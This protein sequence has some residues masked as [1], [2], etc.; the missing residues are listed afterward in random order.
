MVNHF[1]FTVVLTILLSITSFSQQF[2]SFKDPRDGR[3]YKT[4]KIGNQTWM[5]ENL[6]VDKFQNGDPIPEAKTEEE[7]VNAGKNKMPAWCYFNNDPTRRLKYGKLYN[8]YAVIDPRGLTPYSWHI[9]SVEDYKT[10]INFL[11]GNNMAGIKMKKNNGW[12]KVAA[13]K[14][15]SSKVIWISG[16][17]TNSSGW[18]ALPNGARDFIGNFYKEGGV[19]AQFGAWWL[20]SS[21]L[22]QYS[23]SFRIFNYDER[24]GEPEMSQKSEG[25]SV[26]CIKD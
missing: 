14:H 1:I 15:G 9:P 17:G 7:W 18:S 8:W 22:E 24:I 20:S 26:R 23:Y 12:L 2:G 16:D 19:S 21:A 11:G 10:C 13:T 5:A 4:V 25:L 6:D 3:V